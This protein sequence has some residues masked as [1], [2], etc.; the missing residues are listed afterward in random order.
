MGLL[1]CDTVNNVELHYF[2][3]LSQRNADFANRQILMD[4]AVTL[5]IS[6]NYIT[7]DS[8]FQLSAK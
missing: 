1:Q 5:C 4:G 3:I 2:V 7:P 6:V 8:K